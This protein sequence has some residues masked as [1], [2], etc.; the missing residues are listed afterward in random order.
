MTE[1]S[2]S[3][4]Y[5]RIAGFYIC[6]TFIPQRKK[7]IRHANLNKLDSGIKDLLKG[8]IVT[9][10]PRIDFYLQLYRT[11]PSVIKKKVSGRNKFYLFFY[12][13]EKKKIISFQYISMGQLMYLITNILNKLLAKHGGFVMHSS[14]NLINNGAFVF[15][16][17]TNAGKSTM[18]SFLSEKY[19]PLCDDSSIIKREDNTYYLYQAPLFEKNEWFKKGPKRYPIKKIFF[20]KKANIFSLTKINDKKN[21]LKQLSKQL[22]L[23][24][25]Q[26]KLQAKYFLRF[27]EEFNN[28]YLLSFAKDK[29]GVLAFIAKTI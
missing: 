5:L 2:K 18:M 7:N 22:W 23:D 19:Q 28:F 3:K 16:G 29:K 11:L 14:A 25:K 26:Y 8:F 12:E 17:K 20:L 13:E 4:Y 21:I 6:I 1:S 24:N 9:H 15:T 10:P 27:V